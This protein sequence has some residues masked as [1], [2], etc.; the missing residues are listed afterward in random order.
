MT[1]EELELPWKRVF[2]L[3]WE[4]LLRGSKAIAA[5]IA[6]DSGEILSEGRNRI[7]EKAFPNEIVA[8]AE[9]EA[10]I[11]LD[12]N[13][14]STPKQYI[15]YAGLEPCPMCMGTIV[16]GHIRHLRIAAK[17]EYGGA[18]EL[19]DKSEFLKSKHI[20]VTYENSIL[21][22]VQRTL[23]VIREL[24]Y[25]KDEIKKEQ[26][27]STIRLSYPQSIETAEE[28]VANGYVERAIKEKYAF[29]DIFDTIV[30]LYNGKI[31]E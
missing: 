8:H 28:L 30:E 17:D 10:V 1:Y 31:T 12:V 4:S 3:A 23:Q 9:L 16:M 11:N 22:Y 24:L 5:V 20:E 18:V 19:L 21:G 6:T 27:I 2:T 7:Y 25:T 26:I 29:A 15:L 14:Y 13:K